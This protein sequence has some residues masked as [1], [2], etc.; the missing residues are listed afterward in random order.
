M[1][2]PIFLSPLIG[3]LIGLIGFPPVYHGITALLL[4][5]ALISTTLQ[6]PRERLKTVITPG[7]ESL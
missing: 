7:D 3:G 2:A 1:A 5:G 6:E 4:A